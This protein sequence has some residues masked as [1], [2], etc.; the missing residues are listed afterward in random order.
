MLPAGRVLRRVPRLLLGLV[1]FGFGLGMVVLGGYGLP[2]WDVF[3]Q[4]LAERTPLTIGTAVIVIGVVL[5]IVMLV[6]H[7]PIGVG[8]L[9]NVV[10]IGL[11]LDAT[12]WLIDAPVN[13]AARVLLTLTGPIVVAI[14]SGYYIGVRLGPGPRDGLMTALGRRGVTLW[15][16]RFGI[17]AVAL[18][19]GVLLGGTAGWGTV[20]FLVSIGPAV[21][22]FLRYLSVPLEPGERVP[23]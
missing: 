12:L 7:E 9:A 16:A 1:L 15:K 19:S 3:H 22:F 18:S 13:T 6:L 17:E 23:A 14:G 8:T 21:Q 11:V 4:G 2:G 10:V 20:W 5:L